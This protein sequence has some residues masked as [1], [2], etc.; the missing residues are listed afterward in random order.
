MAQPRCDL[1]PSHITV[2]NLQAI[3]FFVAIEQLRLITEVDD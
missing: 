2:L 3:I 1:F